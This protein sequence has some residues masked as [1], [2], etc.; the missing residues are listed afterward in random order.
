MSAFVPCTVTSRAAL[1]SQ[2]RRVR[3]QG[4]TIVDQELK[5]GLPAVAAAGA[6]RSA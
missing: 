5:E 3:D 6:Q 2:L 1:R 4:W